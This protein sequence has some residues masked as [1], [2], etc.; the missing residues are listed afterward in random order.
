ME[1]ET[2]ALVESLEYFRIFIFG[3]Q[4]HC[5]VDQKAV[6]ALLTQEHLSKYVRYRIRIQPYQPLL[7]Y[8]KGCHNRADWLSR[9][10][11][12]EEAGRDFEA[13]VE[14][15]RFYAGRDL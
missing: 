10:A 15:I 1:K 13:G 3:L 7:K 11:E 6:L 14:R 4:I 2:L 12:N 9:F 5:L 8:V